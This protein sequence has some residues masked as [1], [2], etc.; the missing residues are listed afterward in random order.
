MSSGYA[1]YCAPIFPKGVAKLRVQLNFG[2]F[3]FRPLLT[4]IVLSCFSPLAS[5]RL[6]LPEVHNLLVVSGGLEPA[7]L[8]DISLLQIHS[9]STNQLDTLIYF[10]QRRSRTVSL[11]CRKYYEPKP[12]CF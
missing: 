10:M 2:C 5:D 8:K 12:L 7:D 1:C 11:R 6:F 9:Y 3:L 4:R